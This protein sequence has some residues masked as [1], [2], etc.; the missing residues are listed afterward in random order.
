VFH[1]FFV[2]LAKFNAYP[3]L[4]VRQLFIV[5]DDA[6]YYVET[7]LIFIIVYT[8]KKTQSVSCISFFEDILETA[9]KDW[10]KYDNL[11]D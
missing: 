1:S 7:I 3:C 4:S 9:F 8:Y 5:T 11:T 10:K 6:A 2:I